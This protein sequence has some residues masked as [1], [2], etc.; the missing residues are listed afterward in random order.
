MAEG[1]IKMKKKE[2]ILQGGEALTFR[3][4]YVRINVKPQGGGGLPPGNLTFLGNPESN[5]LPLDN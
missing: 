4:C 3:G 5:S 2:V 1:T